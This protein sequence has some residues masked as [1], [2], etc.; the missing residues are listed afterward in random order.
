MVHD[1]NVKLTSVKILK[2]VYSSFKKLS[3]DS[4]ITLQKIVNRSLDRYIKDETFRKDMNE[5]SVKTSKN[6]GY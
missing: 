2:E 4:D 5:Y 6:N 3:F 1:E